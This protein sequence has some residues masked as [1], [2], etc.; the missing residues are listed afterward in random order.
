MSGSM[1]LGGTPPV[2]LEP[3][4]PKR[5]G[6]PSK[7]GSWPSWTTQNAWDVPRKSYLGPKTAQDG[8]KMAPRWLQDGPRWP[9]MAP[10][11]P[12]MAPR[13]PKMAPRWPQDGPRWPQD[14]SRWPREGP[15]MTQEGPK[16]ARKDGP[17][18]GSSS[19]VYIYIC[20]TI[21]KWVLTRN[22]LGEACNPSDAGLGALKLLKFQSFKF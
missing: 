5:V 8:P 18:G 7:I 19:K 3:A 1:V 2:Y 22:V 13:W 21:R 6:R 4:P 16:T 20:S 12:K 10:R 14:G 15:K 9:K 17:M 11:W